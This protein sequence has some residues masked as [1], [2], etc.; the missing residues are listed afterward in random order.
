MKKGKNMF[1]LAVFAIFAIPLVAFGSYPLTH[2]PNIPLIEKVQPNGKYI[3]Y[4]EK[5]GKWQEAG[6]M[7]FD[8]Y[9]R[10]REIDIKN[11]I[12]VNRPVKVRL[13]QQGGG[14]AHIDSVFLNG[15]PPV[16]V[17]DIDNG[18]KKLSKK[19]FDVIDSF[20][21]TIE[22]TFPAGSKNS[23]LK[24]TARVEDTTISK[25]PFQF[26]YENIY[27]TI[28][29][30][31]KFY[32]YKINNKTRNISSDEK[33]FFKVLSP[34]GSGHP[35]GF[36]YGWVW[37]DETNLY[38]RIDFTPDNTMDGNKDYAKVYIKTD[39]GIKEFRIS[40]FDRKWGEVDFT[41]T[42]KVAYQHKL[43][44]FRIPL[45]K[46]GI[47]QMKDSSPLQLAFAAYGTASPG[48]YATDMAFDP[49]NNRHLAVFM[50]GGS[51]SDVYGLFIDCNGNPIGN[52]FWI[53][54]NSNM[55][56]APAVAFDTVNNR[57]LVAWEEFNGAAWH[58]W[59][60]LLDVNGAIINPPG[61]F[62]ISNASNDSADQYSP[63]ISFGS[64]D[65]SN[66]IFVVMWTDT[67][68]GTAFD[69]F[70]R[71]VNPT[72]PPLP[73]LSY[74]LSN[75]ANDQYHGSIAYNTVN[76]QFMV[77]WQN[78]S[79]DFIEGR[80]FNINPGGVVNPIAAAFTISPNV[81]N[82]FKD[83]P[84]LAYDPV[85]NQ[86]LVV[87]HDDDQNTTDINIYGRLVNAANETLIGLELNISTA[88]DNQRN[89]QIAYF[90]SQDRYLTAW[91]N[92]AS[93]SDV[94]GQYIDAVSGLL[95]GS[96]FFVVGGAGDQV[97]AAF[98]Y[99]SVAGNLL[100]AYFNQPVQTTNTLFHLLGPP[101]SGTAIPTLSEWGMIIFMLFAGLGAIYY[102]R[103]LRRTE[104]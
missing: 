57:Y 78:G 38:I 61:I 53:S 76:N 94:Y 36:T 41:Y 104:S 10:E 74:N 18:L 59:G 89:P 19:D 39:N 17:N 15:N 25:A 69:T 23:I 68:T 24:M 65:S 34:T 67:G 32:A 64:D 84:V 77:V 27:K 97:P 66:P 37:N 56:T 47:N 1:L 93:G 79:A 31:S 52:P 100:L 33:P 75:A 85:R 49:S 3:V 4:V 82:H 28:D 13:I 70:V 2:Y 14:A 50:T 60:T 46:A 98:S 58:I 87:W 62:A 26:P 102:L 35:S 88:A 5:E 22:M 45:E 73:G 99:N 72:N 80:R 51:N 71:V 103:R 11:Y 40:E 9:F 83:D 7:V 101:C 96:N 6:S 55:E 63:D 90:A 30:Q 43:Y 20:E 95:S 8:M 42:D 44:N 86:Y 29:E 92:G 81:A 21:K 48:N 91:R 16:K 12:S 54:N